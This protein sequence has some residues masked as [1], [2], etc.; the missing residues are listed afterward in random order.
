MHELGHPALNLHLGK[1]LGATA[2]HYI[3]R[4]L[5]GNLHLKPRHVKKKIFLGMETGGA[6][7]RTAGAVPGML[8][9]NRNTARL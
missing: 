7:T 4:T 5:L 3:L 2:T 1:I 6:I 9:T 8:C